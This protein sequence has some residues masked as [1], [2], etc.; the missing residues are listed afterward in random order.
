MNTSLTDLSVIQILDGLKKAEF[1]C[2]ELV[3]AYLER[4]AILEPRVHAFVTLA[5][6]DA[7]SLADKADA[8]Y[9]SARHSGSETAPAGLP[10]AVKDLITVAGMCV[11]AA[12]RPFSKILCRPSPPTRCGGCWTPGP[13]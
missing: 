3:Q 8:R 10:I 2:R 7:L 1:S 6:E 5:E 13:L 9:A 11:V 12:A 4:I